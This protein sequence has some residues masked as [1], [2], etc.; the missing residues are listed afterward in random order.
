MPDKV[1]SLTKREGKINDINMQIS[2]IDELL[3]PGL[4]Y[5]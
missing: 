5:D 3:G 1:T 2:I 4:K